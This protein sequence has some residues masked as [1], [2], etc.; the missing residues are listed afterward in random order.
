MRRGVVVGPEA[1][2]VA[3]RGDGVGQAD[4]LALDGLPVLVLLLTHEERVDRLP[5]LEDLDLGP[6]AASDVADQDLAGADGVRADA[7][8]L[9]GVVG[10]VEAGGPRAAARA[11]IQEARAQVQLAAPLP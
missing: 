6:N 5:R 11:P 8:E 2:R 4:V 9:V 3:A 1:G 10:R 7:Q